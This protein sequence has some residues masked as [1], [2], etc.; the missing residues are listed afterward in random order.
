VRLGLN[1]GRASLD[2]S[3]FRPPKTSPQLDLF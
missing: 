3:Q 1:Q 2:T